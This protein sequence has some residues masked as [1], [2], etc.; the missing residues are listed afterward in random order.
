VLFTT[1]ALAVV[2]CGTITEKTLEH[3][4][5]LMNA[6]FW[7]ETVEMQLQA[8]KVNTAF[9]LKTRYRLHAVAMFFIVK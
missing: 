3:R 6:C 9:E 8:F 5:N 4:I 2:T 7:L 1:E